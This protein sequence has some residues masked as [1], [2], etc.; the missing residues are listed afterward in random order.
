MSDLQD[1]QQNRR[2]FFRA[3]GRNV[4]LTSLAGLG[5]K[6][7]MKTHRQSK[8]ETCI[9][10]GICRHCNVLDDCGLP[11]ALSTKQV[12]MGR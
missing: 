3:L 2:D 7:A 1:Q 11:Q 12:T 6:L 9:G 4:I 5:V 10:S 8:N